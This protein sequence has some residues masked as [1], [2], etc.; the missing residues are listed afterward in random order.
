MYHFGH[1]D[2]FTDKP[3]YFLEPDYMTL[4]KA[5]DYSGRPNRTVL[6]L[7]MMKANKDAIKELMTSIRNAKKQFIQD[8]ELPDCSIVVGGGDLGITFMVGSDQENWIRC[9]INT[10]I[11]NITRL[12]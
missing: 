5:V 3:R 11:L 4:L 2:Q 12:G 9:S 7:E 10:V 1:K 6:L 8:G